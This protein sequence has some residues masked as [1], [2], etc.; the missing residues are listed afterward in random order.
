MKFRNMAFPRILQA[1]RGLRSEMAAEMRSAP[2]TPVSVPI[3]PNREMYGRVRANP[4][5]AKAP[6][7]CPMNIRSTILQSDKTIIFSMAGQA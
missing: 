1:K 5:M 4:Q 2:P 6:A 3:V 7:P